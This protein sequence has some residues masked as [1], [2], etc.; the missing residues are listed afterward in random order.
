MPPKGR[1]KLAKDNVRQSPRK[2]KAE[3]QPEAQAETVDAND[4]PAPA[5]HKLKKEDI[6]D[7]QSDRPKKKVKH[8]EDIVLDEPANTAQSV[9]KAKAATKQ[10]PQQEVED[11]ES[12]L[13]LAPSEDEKKQSK[14]P[15]K[16]KTAEEKEAEKM[17]LA[18][19]TEGLSY[20]VGAHVSIAK[21]V[22]N[23]VTNAVHIGG[24][25]FALFLQSQRKWENPPLKS[26]NQLAFLKACSHHKYDANQHVVPHASYL[27]NLAAKDPTSA[28]KSYDFFLDDLKRCE[29]LGIRYYNFHPGSTNKEPL[30]EAIKRLSDN[31]N[32]LLAETK[33]VTPLLENM[34]GTESIIGSRLSDLAQIIAGVRPEYQ[35]RIGICI[36]T[37]HAFAAGLDLRTPE[38]FEKTLKEIDDVV[39]LKYLKAMH[40]NDS[41]GMFESKK[42]LHQNIG[43]GFLGLRPFHS[44]MNE[45]RLANIPLIL[46]TPSEKP[47]PKNPKKTIEDKSVWSKEI[48]MLESLI[49][50]DPDGQEYKTLEQT[51]ADQGKEERGKM[52]TWQA[53]K[54]EKLR[55]QGDKAAKGQ[56]NIADM[57][58]GK[59]KKSK[60]AKSE[61]ELD[62]D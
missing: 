5:Q 31:L 11:S 15:K 55:R 6:T 62:S 18:S 45:P 51:L 9:K 17:P 29:R 19:R 26:E 32:R 44:I 28:K 47:D 10:K 27:C 4:L 54:D 24:N 12:E 57:F 56:K 38:A 61:D 42:D 34:A 8:S 46:E 14:S 21:G 50:M 1:T 35:H 33:T 37:C 49:G 59:G 52:E 30:A 25:A 2:R 41:K 43:L 48:K 53:E 36:D 22:E 58:G 23:A 20:F 16:R 60:K 7:T 40:I 3:A 13:S 39:G